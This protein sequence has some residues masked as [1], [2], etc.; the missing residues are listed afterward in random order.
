MSLKQ[1]INTKRW[2]HV[3]RIRERESGEEREREMG[4]RGRRRDGSREIFREMHHYFGSL[5]GELQCSFIWGFV[6]AMPKL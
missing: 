3:K 1:Q 2:W 4:E 5:Y 6:E